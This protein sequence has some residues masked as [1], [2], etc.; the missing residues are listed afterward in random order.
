M[1]GPDLEILDSIE[2]KNIPLIIC[3]GID[4]ER[5]EKIMFNKV[6]KCKH[7]SGYASSSSFLIK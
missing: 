3:G 1:N 6:K 5:D 4:I 2:I 7:F